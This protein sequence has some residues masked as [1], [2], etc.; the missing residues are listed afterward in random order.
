MPKLPELIDLGVDSL[1]VE[2]RNKSTYYA[3]VVARTYRMA[4]DAYV[5]DP[6][7]WNYKT[8]MRELNSLQARGYTLAFHDGRLSNLAH[9]YEHGRSSSH[10]EYAGVIREWDGDDMIF[11]IKNFILPGD[12]LEFLSPQVTEPI[13]VRLQEFVDAKTGK[14]TEKVSPGQGKS[15]RIPASF[16]T[17]LADTNI[18]D[19]LPALTVSRKNKV[20]SSLEHKHLLL[21]NQSMQAEIEQMPV[22]DERKQKLLKEMREQEDYLKSI[23]PS[24][25]GPRMGL[26][27]CCGKGCNGCLVFWQDEKFAGK[28]DELLAKGLGK[29]IMLSGQG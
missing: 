26:E 27:G 1:K 19:V 12:L 2:G 14:V 13:R 17:T 7:N 5:K 8:Y 28:R 24:K 6:E 16:F 10:W 29:G 21:K 4:I 22:N 18:K 9:D 23:K 11:E 25:K 15:I 20:L 3:A